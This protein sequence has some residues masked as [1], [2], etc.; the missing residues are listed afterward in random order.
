MSDPA[1][2]HIEAKRRFTYMLTIECASVGT[3]DLAKVE[4]L[5]DLHFQE[6]VYDDQFVEHLDE[7]TAVTIQVIPTFG[8][9]NG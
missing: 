2:T 7:T 5:L 3:A 6:L 1:A 8:Q 4:N 9:E